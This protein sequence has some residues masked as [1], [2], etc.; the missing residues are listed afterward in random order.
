[1]FEPAA[2]PFIL[3]NIFFWGAIACGPLRSLDCLGFK[4][5]IDMAEEENHKEAVQEEATAQEEVKDEAGDVSL[6]R[7]MGLF[8]YMSRAN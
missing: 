6:S 7:S 3:R 8:R 2:N 1:M 4:K 5:R